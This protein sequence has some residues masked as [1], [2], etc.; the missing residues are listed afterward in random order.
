MT[1]EV[2]TALLDPRVYLLICDET[3]INRILESLRRITHEIAKPLRPA[4]PI[5]INVDERIIAT[6]DVEIQTLRIVELRIGHR[7]DLRAPVR[8]MN[9]PMLLA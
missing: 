6:I 5:C 7:L 3:I 1:T 4:V 9:R 2:L 8:L